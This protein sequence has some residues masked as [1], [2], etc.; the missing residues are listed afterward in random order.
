METGQCRGNIHGTA[1]VSEVKKPMN[2][3]SYMKMSGIEQ[4]R[5][6]LNEAGLEMFHLCELQLIYTKEA[7]LTRDHDL[8]AEVIFL[9]KLINAMGLKIDRECERFL[10]QY[11]PKAH[12]LKFVLG[13]RKI[14]FGLQ[15]MGS[16]CVNMSRYISEMQ[17]LPNR[18]VLS[19]MEMEE[20][21][22]DAISMVKDISAS[23]E[24]GDSRDLRK[25]HKRQEQLEESLRRSFEV[26]SVEVRKDPALVRDYL[27][28]YTLVKKLEMMGSLLSRISEEVIFY[29]EAEG[30]REQ[31]VKF[32]LD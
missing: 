2:D 12:D 3:H 20:M 4:N 21:F 27:L 11:Q 23:Y 17:E 8:A 29:C 10:M 7:F 14:N 9:D 31:E 19:M 5:I 16:Y 24:D 6:V 15:R 32:E 25:I 1:P 13:L 18:K 28:Q 26:V 22:S 30:W